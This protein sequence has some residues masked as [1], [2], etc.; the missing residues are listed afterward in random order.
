MM[1]WYRWHYALY[2]AKTLHLTATQ[3]GI[4]RRLIDWNMSTRQPVPDNDQALASIARVGLDEWLENAKVVR[5]FFSSKAGFLHHDRCDL[6]LNW[7]DG[8]ASI[9]SEVAKKGALARW[10]KNNELDAPSM[11]GEHASTHARGEERRKELMSFSPEFESFW[12]AFPRQRRGN[13]KKAFQA[14][15]RASQRTDPARIIGAVAMY[16]KSNE[17]ANG[18]AKGAEAWLNDDR[19]EIDYGAKSKMNGTRKLVMV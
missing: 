4:Y 19:W 12:E 18:Y 13:K 7:Q 6:E 10:N 11:L 15:N 8:K 5:N 17:V 1:D 14:F 3:D 9:R 2:A 16:A